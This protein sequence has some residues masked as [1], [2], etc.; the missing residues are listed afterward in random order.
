MFGIETQKLAV[1]DECGRIEEVIVV[2][3]GQAQGYGETGGCRQQIAQGRAGCG[4]EIGLE[5]QVLGWIAGDDQLGEE[6]EV[7]ALLAGF[8]QPVADFLCV[9]LDIAHGNVDLG[10]GKA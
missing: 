2:G 7:G 10:Q 9:A 5:Q 4:N 1:L 8:L 6:N 3:D